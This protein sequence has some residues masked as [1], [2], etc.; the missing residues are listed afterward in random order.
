VGLKNGDSGDEGSLTIFYKVEPNP[1][2]DRSPAE[3]LDHMGHPHS[4]HHH[5]YITH[6]ILHFY[7]KGVK[8]KVVIICASSSGLIFIII[9]I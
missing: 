6:N 7:F 3:L 1:M 4:T 5:V 8:S 9:I 2:R